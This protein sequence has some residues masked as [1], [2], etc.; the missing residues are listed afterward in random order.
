M[1]LRS[2]AFG[3]NG[4]YNIFFTLATSI[5]IH[6]FNDYFR[7][8]DKYFPST[9]THNQLKLP[10]TTIAGNRLSHDVIIVVLVDECLT[11]IVRTPEIIDHIIAFGT[12]N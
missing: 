5:N 9:G 7:G 8:V 11:V 4:I 1:I 2:K 10:L 12:S 3:T 6:S